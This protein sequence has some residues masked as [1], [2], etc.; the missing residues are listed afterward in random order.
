M[1][2][3]NLEL[4]AHVGSTTILHCPWQSDNQFCQVQWLT[5][6]HLLH[7]DFVHCQCQ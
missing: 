2:A 3:F 4:F 5:P 1:A 6:N 7:Y